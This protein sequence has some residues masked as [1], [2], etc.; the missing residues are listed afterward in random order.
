[1]RWGCASVCIG[2]I[3]QSIGVGCLDGLDKLLSPEKLGVGVSSH[4]HL[5]K[6]AI[7]DSSWAFMLPMGIDSRLSA[8]EPTFEQIVSLKSTLSC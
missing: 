4:S 6:L 5:E 3:D 7:V 2:T 8:P 1:M